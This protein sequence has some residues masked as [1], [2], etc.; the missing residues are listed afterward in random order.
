MRQRHV[1][2]GALVLA[3]LLGGLAGCSDDP[4][5]DVADP[6]SEATSTSTTEPIS[7]PATSEPTSEAPAESAQEFIRRWHEVSDAMQ[8]SGET[9]E[10]KALGPGCR[11]CS[12]TADLIEGYYVAGGFVE[13]EGTQVTSVKRLGT[14]G[15]L[16][17]F[18]VS[19]RSAPTRYQETRGGPIKTFPGGEDI[20][21]MKLERADGVWMVVDLGLLAS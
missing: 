5:P 21:R 1:G 8:L 15:E 2:A 14:V 6:T 17:E 16:V 12:D 13:Y 9:A 4:D 11:P 3:L 10:Y 20:I 7:D 19:R 18:E